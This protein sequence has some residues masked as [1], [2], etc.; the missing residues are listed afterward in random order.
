MLSRARRCR[1][2]LLRREGGRNFQQDERY[3]NNVPSTC[4]TKWKLARCRRYES[5]LNF[6]RLCNREKGNSSGCLPA[7]RGLLQQHVDSTCLHSFGVKWNKQINRTKS[8]CF[9]DRNFHKLARLG[10]LSLLPSYLGKKLRVGK[11][12]HPIGRAIR[13]LL[14]KLLRVH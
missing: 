1:W 10:N 3:G 14:S 9:V 7:I 4:Y 8:F 5:I 13:E 2:P 11:A 12:F 6:V